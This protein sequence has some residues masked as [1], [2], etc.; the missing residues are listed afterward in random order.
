MTTLRRWCLVAVAAAVVIAAPLLPR[1]LPATA[2]D[3]SAGELLSRVQ[4]SGDTPYSGYVET[5]GAVQLAVGNDFSDLSELFGDRLRLRVWWD[6]EDSWRVNRLLLSGEEDLVHTRNATTVYDYE[7]ARAVRSRDPEIRLPRVSDLVPPSLARIVTDGASAEEVSRLP[8]RRI[9]GVSAPGLR[10]DPA[11]D[12]TSIDHVDL[13]IDEE[14]GLALTVEVYAAGSDAAVL[15]TEFREFSMAQPESEEVAATW[16]GQV[17]QEV[18]DTIDLADAAN[19]Y[20]PFR[21]P[22]SVAGLE[23]LS[24]DNGAVGVYG[25]GVTRLIAVPLRDQ[26]ADALREA[27]VG[28]PTAV[29]SDAGTLVSVGPLSVFLTTNDGFDYVLAGTVT[30]ETVIEAAADVV[31]GIRLRREFR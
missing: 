17:E 10:L 24:A 22:R 5:A 6:S 26:D 12:Q 18:A 1:L 15:T 3:V 30:A 20:A 21:V 4:A 23:R 28:S 11:S 7:R 13:W 19:R 31:S 14:S 27:L 25:S 2:S 16:S 9:A 29:I 8:A